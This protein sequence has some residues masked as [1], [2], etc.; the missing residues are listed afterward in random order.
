MILLF[1]I[2][3][4]SIF[5]K[6][7]KFFMTC[8]QKKIPECWI[9]FSDDFDRKYKTETNYKTNSSCS[10]LF[11]FQMRLFYWHIDKAMR[12]CGPTPT[13]VLSN[14]PPPTSTSSPISLIMQRSYRIF[15]IFILCDRKPILKKE[16]VVI[17]HTI[18]L[19]WLHNF[20][21]CVVV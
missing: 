18:C 7:C 19:L 13:I 1:W 6:S 5:V 4:N 11:I 15:K 14:P 16:T 3:T 2:K 10:Y 12:T 20:A 17:V 21:T 9:R 8:L